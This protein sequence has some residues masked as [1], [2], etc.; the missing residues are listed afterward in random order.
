MTPDQP[1]ATASA[2][3][4]PVRAAWD[5]RK[6][7]RWFLAEFLVVVAGVLVALA[8]SAWWQARQE[9]AQE[10]LYLLQLD[11][12]LLATETEMRE[13][14]AM[15]TAGAVAAGKVEHAYWGERPINQDALLDAFM[16]PWR[17]SRFRPVLGNIE[18]LVSSG[19]ISVIRS[20]PLRTALVS[21]V[22]WSKARLEDIN[23]YDETYYRP[24]VNELQ[25]QLDVSAL[26]LE[27][28][29]LR[30]AGQ[31]HAFDMS[32]VA[33]SGAPPFPVDMDKIFGN[34]I[35]YAA[36]GKIMLAHRN[37]AG[38][39][40]A[41]LDR[42][43]QLHGQVHRQLHGVDEP[44]NC[45][46][47]RVAGGNEYTGSC[48]AL[49]SMDGGA[50]SGQQQGARLSV[51]QVDAITSGRWKIDEVPATQWSG[52][53]QAK[54][55]EDDGVELE[56]SLAGDGVLRTQSGW[57]AVRALEVGKDKARL[58]F[59]VDTRAEIAANAMDVAILRQAREL[60]ADTSG[61]D[62]Q[63]NRTCGSDKPSLSLYCALVQATRMQSGGVHHRR[64]ALQLV[65]ARVDVRSVGR[66][67]QHRLRDYNNDPRTTLA[68]VQQVLDEATNMALH[69]SVRDAEVVQ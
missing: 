17:T 53:L 54:G 41:I 68:D 33:A 15:L 43:R 60:L 50:E 11:A 67:Y 3:E 58:S 23:R 57:F 25:S 24:A 44:G 26:R 31:P 1:P 37:Q 27:A 5:P 29:R 64:P 46:L 36:Y 21:Y 34:R 32:S 14:K 40:G 56:T 42:A 2:T 63:G 12:D 55:R 30:N 65:R 69:A 51:H 9:R 16:L 48:G 59:R 19:D 66:G 38:Q 13:A 10:S 49:F 22:E 62:R 39:Y 20:A 8:V 18:S 35:V 4:K 61:W 47:E 28:W 45:Q 7:L 52:K 6:A